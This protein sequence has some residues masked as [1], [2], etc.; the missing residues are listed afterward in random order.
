MMEVL[1]VKMGAFTEQSPIEVTAP[2]TIKCKAKVD[3]D[4]ASQA[5]MDWGSLTGVGGQ[6]SGEIWTHSFT[7]DF[8]WNNQAANR[9]E[10]WQ[11][12][13]VAR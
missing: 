8:R 13:G 11:F 4:R 6:K 3:I 10:A 12:I 7:G 5:T 2:V 1:D 9:L